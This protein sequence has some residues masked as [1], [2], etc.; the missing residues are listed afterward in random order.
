MRRWPGPGTGTSERAMRPLQVKLEASEAQETTRL[1]ARQC[2]FHTTHRPPAIYRRGRGMR[3]GG[4]LVT[5]VTRGVCVVT[6]L[7]EVSC[8]GSVTR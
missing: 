1:I 7:R 8:C 6:R 4:W 5:T 3:L 2:I